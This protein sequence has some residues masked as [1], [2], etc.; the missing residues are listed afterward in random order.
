[1]SQTLSTYHGRDNQTRTGLCLPLLTFEC[2]LM[3]GKSVNVVMMLGEENEGMQKT[4][5]GKRVNDVPL[6]AF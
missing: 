6:D 1:M 3:D 2:V 5:S 4:V